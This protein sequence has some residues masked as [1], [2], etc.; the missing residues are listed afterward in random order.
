MSSRRKQSTG[1]KIYTG[2]STFGMIMADF[3][4]IIGTVIG[5]IMITAGIVFI[6]RQGV[7]TQQ[8][9]GTVKS[10]KCNIPTPITDDQGKLIQPI[11]YRW[12][13]T[14]TVYNADDKSANPTTKTMQKT[15]TGNN[16]TIQP[17][18]DGESIPIW[19]NS[20]DPKDFS[21][22][23]DDTHVIGWFLVIIGP[24]LIIGSIAWAYFATK[25]KIIGAYEGVRTGVD[26]IRGN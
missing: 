10:T 7:Y 21:L 16:P 2:V 12:N 24:I 6:R 20:K 15:L 8:G 5:I 22:S 14:I 18:Q 26:M 1:S 9:T 19:I 3:K 13:C 17:T 4:A 25:Y 23:S 11:Q